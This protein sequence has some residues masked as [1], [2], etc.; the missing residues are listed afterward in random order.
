M[1]I[2]GAFTHYH[3]PDF[4]RV[5]VKEQDYVPESA[6]LMHAKLTNPL[7]QGEQLAE[8]LRKSKRK[9]LQSKTRGVLYGNVTPRERSVS[10]M[11]TGLQVKRIAA[12]DDQ[13][14]G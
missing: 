4:H 10:P 2:V 7:K 8:K 6:T 1:K 9:Q 12:T 11:F 14:A 13:P 3:G 5:A